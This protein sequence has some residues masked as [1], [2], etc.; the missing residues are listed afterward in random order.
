[1]TLNI[2][3]SLH[4]VSNP[5][6][7]WLFISTNMVFI[8]MTYLF[9]SCLTLILMAMLCWA[10][11]CVHFYSQD[12]DLIGG[13]NL[14]MSHAYHDEIGNTRITLRANS[15]TVSRRSRQKKGRETLGALR[16]NGRHSRP[17]LSWERMEYK[18]ETLL[19]S[20]ALPMSKARAPTTGVGSLCVT[21]RVTWQKINN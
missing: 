14:M 16:Q 11:F 1:M 10:P 4:F 15:L 8:S 2:D 13:Y 19:L 20:P 3:W 7:K 6:I 12:Y 5:E 17:Q 21:A 9:M 18:P